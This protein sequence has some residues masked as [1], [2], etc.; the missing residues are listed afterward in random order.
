MPECKNSMTG[1]HKLVDQIGKNKG[2]LVCQYCLRQMEVDIKDRPLTNI[3]GI[4]F[5]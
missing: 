4:K 2:K 5:D 3:F 1:R